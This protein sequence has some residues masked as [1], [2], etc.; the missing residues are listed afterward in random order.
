MPLRTQSGRAC[1]T[2]GC[3][4]NR[5]CSGGKRIETPYK[6]VN[7][8]T[9]P[10]PLRLISK[11]AKPYQCPFDAPPLPFRVYRHIRRRLAATSVVEPCFLSIFIANGQRAREA[12]IRRAAVFLS[13]QMLYT[14]PWDRSIMR[15]WDR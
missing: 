5:Y 2:V 10:L 8:P 1:N 4:E 14:S 12:C 3:A 7:L 9:V 15:V 11:V 13:P 6:V